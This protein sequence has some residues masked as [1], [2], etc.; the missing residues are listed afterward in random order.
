MVVGMRA[1][2]PSE[3]GRVSFVVE[4]LGKKGE[5][6]TRRWVVGREGRGVAA[7][8]GRTP[9]GGRRVGGDAKVMSLGE[10]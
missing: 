4:T 8:A 2:S 7:D 10:T 6:R 1:V 9:R 3:M 5:I